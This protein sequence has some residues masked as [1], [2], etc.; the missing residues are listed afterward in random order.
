MNK[1]FS[2]I[3]NSKVSEHV[4][5]Y[6]CCVVILLLSACSMLNT[7]VFVTFNPNIHDDSIFL[8]RVVSPIK[9]YNHN[10]ALAI[11]L[12]KEDTNGLVN[13]VRIFDL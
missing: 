6:N 13:K 8:G 4:E 12:T 2:V 10:M 9:S 7:V 11:L 1:C 5:F 3:E